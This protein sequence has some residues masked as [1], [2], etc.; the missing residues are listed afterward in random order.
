M[1]SLYNKVGESQKLKKDNLLF[2]FLI[3]INNS[4]NFS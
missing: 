2:Y 4:K 1:N 3:K